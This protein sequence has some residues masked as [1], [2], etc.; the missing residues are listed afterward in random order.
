MAVGGDF[1]EIMFH[2]EKTGGSNKSSNHM[3]VFR[4]VI[5]DSGLADLKC[6]DLF[7]WINRKF[8]DDIILERLDR[9][10]SNHEWKSK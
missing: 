3:H 5:D 7:T 4:E 8:G 9:Y 2:R 6:R 1:N 10:F